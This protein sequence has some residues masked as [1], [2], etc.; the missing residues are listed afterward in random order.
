MKKLLLPF[1]LLI[2]ISIGACKIRPLPVEPP[3]VDINIKTASFIVK[4]N[5]MKCFE[6][7]ITF[8]N[9]KIY[10]C[11]LSAVEMFEGS[12][13]FGNDK[14]TSSVSPMI[15]A[16]SEM[17]YKES[18]MEHPFELK[19]SEFSAINKMEDFSLSLDKKFLLITTGFDRLKEDSSEWDEY[20]SLLLWNMMENKFQIVEPSERDSIVSSKSLRKKF[21]SLL[22]SK[23]MKIEGLV[24]LPQNKLIFGVREMGEDFNNPI[25][26]ATFIE[27]TY[28]MEG[29]KMKLNDDFKIS[30]E[31]QPKVGNEVL[32]LSSLIYDADKDA[33]IMTTSL[34]SGDEG[35]QSL[36]SYVWYLSMDDYIKKSNPSLIFDEEVQPLRMPHKAEGICKLSENKYF[37]IHDNDRTDVPV[38]LPNGTITSRKPHQA[39]YSIIQMN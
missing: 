15:M 4:E 27:C 29:D 18:I 7:G 21:L 25:Y 22:N 26:T 19:Q 5:L 32:G 9:G 13:F 1:I 38:T 3:P 36:A 30:Y 6:E 34:E 14:V 8:D 11:E 31:F 28:Y 39:V 23:H 24:I 2:L 33:I 16:N 10:N 20:N 37:I 17:F 12:L 35:E